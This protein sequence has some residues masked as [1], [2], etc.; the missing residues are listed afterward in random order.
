LTTVLQISNTG[1]DVPLVTKIA[2]DDDDEAVVDDVVL[3]LDPGGPP[4]LVVYAVQLQ[5]DLHN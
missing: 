5:A 4:T 3:L 2:S 1:I